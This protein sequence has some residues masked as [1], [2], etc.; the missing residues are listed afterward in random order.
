[1]TKIQILNDGKLDIA[2]GRYRHTRT[3]SNKSVQWSWLVAKLSKTHRTAETYTE[4]LTAKKDRQDEIKDVGGFVG[5]YLSNGIRRTGFVVHRQL[6]TLDADKAPADLWDRLQLQYN[7]AACI[8]STH[9]HSAATPRFRIVMPLDREVTAD[10]YEAIVRRLAE[11]LGIDHFDPTGFRPTQLMYWPST[12]SDGEFVFEYQD[13]PW[14]PADAMLATYRDWKD[15]S[16]WPR[17]AL[18]G[19]QIIR[20]KKQQADPLTKPGLIGAFCRTYSIPEAIETFLSD[21]YE[22]CDVPDR[23]TY[24]HGST[25]AGLVVYEEKFAYSNHGT[26]PASGKLCN[27][28]DLVRLHLFSDKSEKAS[29]DAMIEKASQDPKV[30]RLMAEER[31]QAVIDEFSTPLDDDDDAEDDGAWQGRLTRTKNGDV[32]STIVNAHLILQHDPQLKNA[33]GYNEF[34]RRLSV[35]KKLPW[36]EVGNG[37][38]T[39]T[40]DDALRL[41]FER[42]HGFS[43]K[44]KLLSAFNVIAEQN[45]FHPV[46]EYL[47]GLTWDGQQRV[48]KLFI[49]YLGAEDS[50]YTRAVTRKALTAAVARVF[51]PGIKFDYMLLLV[52]AQGIGKSTLLAKLG[53]P[54]FSD[55]LHTLQDK[56][57]FEA[58]QGAWIIEV[59][60]LAGLRKAEVEAVKH[61]ITKQQD[62]YRPAYGRRTD[63]YPRQCVFFGS[64][65]EANPLKDPTGGRRFWPVHTH[66][67][68]PCLR[69][70]DLGDAERDQIWAEARELYKAGET[71]YLPA[72]LEA[73][74]AQVQR[75]ASEHEPRSGQIEEYLERRIPENWHRLSPADQ[76]NF[77]A[78]FEDPIRVSDDNLVERDR[79][80]VAELWRVCFRGMDR[81]ANS[82]NTRFILNAMRNMAG[83]KEARSKTRFGAYGNQ[84]WFQRVNSAPIE[85]PAYGSNT[86]ELWEQE[87]KKVLPKVYGSKQ[88]EPAQGVEF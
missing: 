41:H 61:F 24:I 63:V 13:G 58:L 44:D 68:Q 59:A 80:C 29:T 78:N 28:F 53:G 16:A 6:L 77:M 31:R 51:Q 21:V 23:Y 74:A 5:G 86:K 32:K 88:W 14:L 57:A 67:L 50:P 65:N 25:A 54:W 49:D 40:D 87:P 8:Y 9:K 4:Y 3:W 2:T 47:S 27:A 15:Q 66:V 71:L 46:R 37:E 33:I 70:A 48:E 38:W 81:D 85:G 76:L 35:R 60:E 62:I 84:R 43:S 55:S 82:H 75:E 22:P 83:W 72:E 11:A 56:G 19:Q 7:N 26:D 17:P 52:G 64:T 30:C 12:S 69:V 36:R 79:I 1:M 20:E 34:T 45:S 39:D 10:E 42:E 18:E 73:I